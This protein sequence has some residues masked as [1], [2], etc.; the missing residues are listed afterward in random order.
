MVLTLRDR[1]G[2]VGERA[3]QHAL[4]ALPWHL[5]PHSTGKT[6]LPAR[7]VL[8][9]PPRRTE[10]LVY[11]TGIVLAAAARVVILVV[12]DTY[13][14]GKMCLSTGMP[15]HPPPELVPAS[16]H[17]TDPPLPPSRPPTIQPD[18]R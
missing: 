18:R 6:A 3:M 13:L 5:E 12:P 8:P 17:P 1:G 2:V 7:V 14:H 10:G 16:I 15:L 9:I 4:A 11:A